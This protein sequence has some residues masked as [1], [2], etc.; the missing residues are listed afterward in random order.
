M[1]LTGQDHLS[2]VSL[3]RTFIYLIFR[4]GFDFW[5]HS[6][7]NKAAPGCLYMTRIQFEVKKETFP[8]VSYIQSVIPR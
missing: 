3:Q 2:S 4:S 8:A 5:V 1:R 7:E 6:E